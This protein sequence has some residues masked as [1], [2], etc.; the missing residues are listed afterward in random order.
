MVLL[1]TFGGLAIAQDAQTEITQQDLDRVKTELE[2]AKAE[3]DR[4]KDV[5]D[6]NEAEL[7][8]IHQTRLL[9]VVGNLG[10]ILGG[11]IPG[12]QHLGGRIDSWK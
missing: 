7:E 10:E 2:I 11:K 9:P 3:A 6:R 4:L 1:F 8:R 5:V 12:H